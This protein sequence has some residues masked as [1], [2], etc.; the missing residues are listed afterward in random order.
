MKTAESR[1]P[2]PLH[3]CNSSSTPV[4]TEKGWRVYTTAVAKDGSI[5]ERWSDWEPGRWEELARPVR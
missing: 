3:F 4:L 1:E 2:K 5:W